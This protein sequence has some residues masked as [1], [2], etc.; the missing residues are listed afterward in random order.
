MADATCQA[1]T[2]ARVELATEPVRAVAPRASRRTDD[3][4]P[5]TVVPPPCP[6]LDMAANYGWPQSKSEL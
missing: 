5:R 4:S 3:E 1:S 6:A 2:S